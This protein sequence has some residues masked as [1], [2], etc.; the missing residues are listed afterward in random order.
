MNFIGNLCVSTDPLVSFI[1]V[2]VIALLLCGAT[3]ISGA[4]VHYIID[5]MLHTSKR[6]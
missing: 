2:S 6:K 4:M 5:R 1:S 3:V